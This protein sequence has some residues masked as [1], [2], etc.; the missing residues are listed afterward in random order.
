MSTRESPPGAKCDS[1]L[2]PAPAAIRACL[3][4]PAAWVLFEWLR[5]W[6]LSGFPWLSLGYA[7]VGSPL[8]GYAP[9]G[10]VLAL[11]FLALSAAG[12]VWLIAMHRAAR[13]RWLIVFVVIVTTGQSLRY[14]E[15][16]AT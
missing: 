7:A 6:I 4:I 12:L 11:S 8:Q 9:L 1:Y 2:N 5:S 10:G 3:L 13:I 16:R 15:S 14:V